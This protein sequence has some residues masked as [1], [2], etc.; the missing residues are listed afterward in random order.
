MWLMIK[1]RAKK[2][3]SDGSRP[4]SIGHTNC[5]KQLFSDLQEMLSPL[6]M[7]VNL[8]SSAR[9]VPANR[10]GSSLLCDEIQK[11]PG[12]TTLLSKQSLLKTVGGPSAFLSCFSEYVLLRAA[13]W[14]VLARPNVTGYCPCL[15]LSV[16][17][18]VL[19][20]AVMLLGGLQPSARVS[21]DRQTH[22]EFERRESEQQIPVLQWGQ[23]VCTWKR[24][25]L[26]GTVPLERRV[27]KEWLRNKWEMKSKP[28]IA[29]S[30]KRSL[31]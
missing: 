10:I 15:L 20:W 26:V 22:T 23:V 13:P 1:E 14:E 5:S 9:L 19:L 30:L 28:N 24:D 8:R 17:W 18:K 7:P 27:Y 29:S 31:W 11:D 4:N 16:G 2:R 21:Y 25:L 12:P 3:D 6:N